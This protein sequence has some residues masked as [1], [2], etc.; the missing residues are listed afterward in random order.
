M[1]LAYLIQHPEQLNKETLHELRTAVAA[2]PTHQ[3]A[4]LLMLQNL[5]LLHD[6]T[7]DEELRRAAAYITDR[8][9]LFNMVEAMHH[10]VGKPK[11]EKKTAATATA[12]N[13]VTPATVMATSDYATYMLTHSDETEKAQTAPANRQQQ[14]IDK[15]INQTAEGPLITPQETTTAPQESPRQPQNE[16]GTQGGFFTET[17]ARIYI[18]QGRYDKALQIIRQLNLNYPEKSRIFASQIRFLEKLIIIQQHQ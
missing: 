15:F 6:P 10:T 11:K 16:G 18:Q 9:V 1:N 8:N 17:L 2:H 7:F 3:T 13:T 4:R 12:A 14:L 5:Y